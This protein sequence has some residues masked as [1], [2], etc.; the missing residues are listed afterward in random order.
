MDCTFLSY[1][2]K[3]GVPLVKR[4]V[5]VDGDAIAE[6]KNVIVPVGTSVKDVIEFCGGYKTEPKKLILG[7]PMMGSAISDDSLFIAKQNNAI[8]AFSEKLAKLQEPTACIHCGKCVDA[9]PMTLVPPNIC[10]AVNA[11]DVEGMLK[12][13]IMNCMECGCCAYSC[14][15]HRHLVNTIRLGKQI[16]NNEKKRQMPLKEG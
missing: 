12:S 3:S 8:L 13:G 14:P 10:K 7:G 4:R 6:P 11:K 1:Y 2:L 9:C 15:A 16:I 5:T